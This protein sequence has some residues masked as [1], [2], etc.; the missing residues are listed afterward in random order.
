MKAV[1]RLVKAS[2]FV[3]SLRKFI[4]Y[5]CLDL[6]QKIQWLLGGWVSIYL[7]NVGYFE[8]IF[9]VHFTHFSLCTRFFSKHYTHSISFRSLWTI[10][11]YGL[12]RSIRTA[13]D[14]TQPTSF[15]RHIGT[16]MQPMLIPNMTLDIEPEPRFQAQSRRLTWESRV[17]TH[18]RSN[19]LWER[20]RKKRLG[21]LCRL[22]A[23]SFIH[24]GAC[25]RL[26]GA[27]GVCAHVMHL[28]TDDMKK[29][30][31]KTKQE[32][33]P[34]ANKNFELPISFTCLFVWIQW[35]FGLKLQ[36]FVKIF[37]VDWIAVSPA[38]R[39]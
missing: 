2:S 10:N 12:R 18:N 15:C 25:V 3:W 37:G 29:M 23:W 30:K 22:N 14:R 20:R 39:K 17:E 26:P 1:W 38:A 33:R 21:W 7:E 13:D 16:K 8:C 4:A 27:C 32:C 31:L 5:E 19:G 36:W 11:P 24:T 34:A 6:N 9:D 35:H 28:M